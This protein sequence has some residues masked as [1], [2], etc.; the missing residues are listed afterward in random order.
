MKILKKHAIILVL[1]LVFPNLGSTQPVPG[2]VFREYY[3]YN[4]SGDAGQALRV[5]GKLDYGGGNLTLSH[6]FDLEHAVK[7][8]V[9][10][11]KI[12]CHDSTRGLSISIN[13]NEWIEIP[14]AENIPYPQ[15]NYQH[16]IYPNVEIP[17][18]SL[19]HGTGNVFKIKVSTTHSWNWPQNLING[20]HFRVYYDAAEKIHPAG[21]I[22]SPRSGDTIGDTVTF[23]ADTTSP[24]AAIK[25]VDFI[26]LYED[27]NFEGDGIYY[28]WH[29]HYFH[30]KIKNHIGTVTE[31]PFQLSWDTTWVPDQ[32][33]PIRVAARIIGETG[34]IYMTEAVT[35]L[36]IER[37]GVSVEL[38]K[39]YNVSTIWV[40]RKYNKSERFDITGDMEKAVST[41]LVWASWSPGY[42]NGIYINDKKVFDKEG[43][44]YQYYAHRVIIDSLHVFKSGFNI[45]KTGQTPTVNGQTVHGMEVNWPGIM[46]L[47]RYEKTTSVHDEHGNGDYANRLI[48]IESFPNPFNSTTS[49]RYTLREQAEVQ[50]RIFSLTGQIVRTLVD[51]CQEA[52]VR[53][54]GWDGMDDTGK[55]V[56]SGVYICGLI[57]NNQISTRKLL[58]MK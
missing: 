55:T 21:N 10:I 6:D 38:C 3:W 51:T 12:L 26:G 40:T 18:S 1:L 35:G 47:I 28:Q 13:D 56:G 33:Q 44:L 27:V 43:P 58:F 11:E 25:Q 42:M 41:Q 2:D 31:A 37:E 16:H 9:V 53:E 14:E 39:P 19:K 5:G 54:I 52:G 48:P 7:A 4:R 32:E 50:C 34:M 17:L 46:V 23:H 20:L 8:E 45:L 22:T 49:I 30:G 15:W 57:V 29:Y 36:E 24:N